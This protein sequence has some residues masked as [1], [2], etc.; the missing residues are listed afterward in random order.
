M[1]FFDSKE[2]VIN[3]RITP[4]GKQALVNGTFKPKYYSFHDDNVI[5][6]SKYAGFDEVQNNI[7]ER[8]Q[9]ETPVVHPWPSFSSLEIAALA[10]YD[11]RM[12]NVNVL[13][14]HSPISP[15]TELKVQFAP[16]WN[17]QFY[18]GTIISS[19]AGLSGSNQVS[20]PITQLDVEQ[21]YQLSIGSAEELSVAN[22]DADA[23]IKQKQIFSDG[24]FLQV[25][26]ENILLDIEEKYTPFE[27]ENFEIA[28][29]AIE[30]ENSTENA[31]RLKF[32]KRTTY[33][34]DDLLLDQPIE[35]PS[36]SIIDDSYVEYYF[37]VLMDSEITTQDI[38][39]AI[40]QLKS[41]GHYL[42]TNFE[43]P[44]DS[45]NQFPNIYM[46]STTEEDIEDC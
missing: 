44:D 8:I 30:F 28:V 37:D 19:S 6:D 18:D 40:S 1:K 35:S 5:Y 7:E 39:N 29:Y 33:I 13:D 2:E 14:M 26:P 16:K 42:D 38:C 11:E 43:C 41:K 4:L 10:L 17:L 20:H 21:T 24:T 34:K 12:V 27:H 46:T 31:R 45:T 25:T 32:K 36:D 3:I 9:D 22:Q 23:A 15:R